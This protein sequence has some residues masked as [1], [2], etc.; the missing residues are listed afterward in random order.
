MYKDPV[1]AGVSKKTHKE[2]HTVDHWGAIVAALN[3]SD[4]GP[5]SFTDRQDPTS[6]FGTRNKQHARDFHDEITDIVERREQVVSVS[7]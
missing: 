7:C 6:I 2:S 4:D 1:A 5:E 3:E